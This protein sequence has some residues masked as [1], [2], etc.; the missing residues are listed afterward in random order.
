MADG[1]LKWAVQKI[2]GLFSDV[3][4]LKADA[5][6]LERTVGAI[7]KVQQ[8]QGLQIDSQDRRISELEREKRGLQISR[9]KARAELTRERQR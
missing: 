5:K 9:G 7:S 1:L 2:H 8:Y 3:N 6:K 4:G